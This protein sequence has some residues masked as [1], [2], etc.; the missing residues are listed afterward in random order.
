MAPAINNVLRRVPSW[1]VYVGGALPAAWLIWA[2]VQNKL[3]ADPLAALEHETGIWALRFM[4]AAL[5]VTPLLKL[6][7]ISLVKFRR[8]LGLLGFVYA[9]LHLTV[10][11]WL[12]H[13]FAWGRMWEEI[14]KR[15]FITV[16]M[17]AFLMLVPLAATSNGLSLRRLGAALWRRIHWWAY[18]ATLLGAVHYLMGVKRWP[19]EPMIYLGIVIG[20][21]LWRYLAKAKSTTRSTQN[22]TA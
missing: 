20:L 13:W 6:A 2:A 7:R 1:L 18:P 9:V 21:L 14:L 17:L 4:I 11:I 10:W 16:G 5:F 19:P 22:A 15:P 8:A 3:G 12:D